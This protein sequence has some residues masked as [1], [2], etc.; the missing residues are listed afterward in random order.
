MILDPLHVLVPRTN[1]FFGKCEKTHGEKWN[2]LCF[3]A[4]CGPKLLPLITYLALGGA[5]I[6]RFLRHAWTRL[7][8]LRTCP[9][10]APESSVLPDMAGPA[11]YPWVEELVGWRAGG[12]VDWLVGLR[13]D[14]NLRT[15]NSSVVC[16]GTS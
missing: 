4:F 5:Q 8:P 15:T 10:V 9:R 16:C 3:S 11:Y 2:C 13:G 14:L 7:L 6:L 12:C 1:V